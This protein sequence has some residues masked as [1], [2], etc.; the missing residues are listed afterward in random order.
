MNK[1]VIAIAMFSLGCNEVL[2]FD[3]LDPNGRGGGGGA[4]GG[5]QAV[6]GQGGLGGSGLA[7][8]QGGL[9]GGGAGPIGGS[10]GS[11]DTCGN[12]VRDGDE[13]DI[14]CGGSTCAPCDNG[15]SCMLHGDCTSGRCE[16][17]QRC[18][19]WA[20]AYGGPANEL[21][22]DVAVGRDGA[23]YH[24]GIFRDAVDFGSGVINAV[25]K[26]D[27]FIAKVTP[28]GTT[29]WVQIAGS[30]EID[31][32]ESIAVS[33]S[34]VFVAGSSGITL[35]LGGA[36]TSCDGVGRDA[37]VAKL[38]ALTG[39]AS[40]ATCRG[41]LSGD[42][43]FAVA[44]AGNDVV[45]AGRFRSPA[46]SFGGTPQLNADLDGGS[47]DVFVVKL[48]G[49]DGSEIWSTSFGVDNGSAGHEAAQDIAVD[50]QG[51]V[52]VVGYY[53]DPF[54]AGGGAL[55]MGAGNNGFAVKLSGIDGGHVWS[56]GMAGP[57]S[58]IFR[59]VKV[60]AN[61]RAVVIGHYGSGSAIAIGG[62]VGVLPASDGT[63]GV[64]VSFGADGAGTPAWATTFSGTASELLFDVAIDQW[65]NV[66]VVGRYNS[67]TI[68]LGDIT[69]TNTDT[70][71]EVFLAKLTGEGVLLTGDG[72]TGVGIDEM[73]G[74]ALHP[75][76]DN[77]VV[78]GRFKESITVGSDTFMSS[79]AMDDDGLLA[80][81]GRLATP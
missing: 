36:N 34:D 11:P 16:A 6:G 23:L 67:P 76:T 60:D 64:A 80:S 24:G 27:G 13:S 39:T 35:T 33:G 25:A 65:G 12:M 17:S 3:D 38:D 29:E 45:V 31:A 41:G 43:A 8:G 18:G 1:T 75:T 4:H 42:E 19:S 73:R 51:D 50:S 63:D 79:G 14:D 37:F 30:T 20:V 15:A 66:H 69:L 77:R 40:W 58:D 52:V 32:V 56:Q 55:P 48:D 57:G 21:G 71:H 44:V 78:V 59:A 81:L 74:L 54:D 2:G 53:L 47:G 70:A 7:G 68:T 5:A 72:I 46:I 10:G 22:Y 26:G 28:P 9:A 49:N 61:D 62:A